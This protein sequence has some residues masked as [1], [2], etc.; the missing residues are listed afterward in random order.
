[1][2]N[3]S[4]NNI[5]T[6][7]FLNL[8]FSVFE[9]IGGLYT[10]SVSIISDSVHDFGDALSIA[11]AWGFEKKS[12][13]NPN[14]K[15]TYGYK[16]FSLIGAL[17]TSMVLVAGS[18]VMIYNAIPRLIKPE[19]VDYNGILLLA[20]I[21]VIINGLGAYKAARGSAI[22]E[23]VVSL[24]LI[25]DVLGWLAVLIS[26]I[27][28]KFLDLPILDPILCL[29]IT[30][31]ILFNVF[32][33]IKSIFEVFLEKSPDNINIDSIVN[34]LL[35]NKKINDIHH[36]HIWSADSII[37]YVTLHVKVND[38]LSTDEI[39]QIKNTIK[40]EFKKSNIEH[41]TLEIEFESEHCNN[42]E[43]AI[44]DS[45]DHSHIGHHHH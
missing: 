35:E 33:N 30:A 44:T 14:K 1:M 6:A 11:I 8:G 22:N 38:G 45:G 21:G 10:N 43:C 2:S 7:F 13:K 27:V 37:P 28:M 29:L 20:V 24:H 41:I 26:G 12:M 40:D 36:I 31:F 32:R 25:E 9:L 17:I 19:Q 4:S 18:V 39:I 34:K 16:R 3:K 5:K 42:V 23:K 15:Y